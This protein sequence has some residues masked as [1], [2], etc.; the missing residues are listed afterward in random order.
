MMPQRASARS[1]KA[2][3]RPTAISLALIMSMR[4]GHGGA[5][6]AEPVGRPEL[7]D[8]AAGEHDDQPVAD[9]EQLI[10]VRRYQEYAATARP[11]LPERPPDEGGGADVKAAR[12]LRRDDQR[13]IV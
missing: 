13:G 3:A 7:S 10:E 6:I 2:S 1:T 11:R 12:R 5:D 9:V 4:S 8:D